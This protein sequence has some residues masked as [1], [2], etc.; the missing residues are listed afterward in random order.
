MIA[1]YV[2]CT[3][4]RGDEAL[5]IDVA[6]L[7]AKRRADAPGTTE[8]KVRGLYRSAQAKY[9]ACRASLPAA[10]MTEVVG[11]TLPDSVKEEDRSKETNTYDLRSW[12]REEATT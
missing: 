4:G 7:A 3:A 2:R 9:G 6:M 11:V 10:A 8:A 1:S 12:K 5:I